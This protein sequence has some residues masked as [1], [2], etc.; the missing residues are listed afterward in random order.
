MAD[1]M[2]F[3]FPQQAQA[4]GS[5]IA[6]GWNQFLSDPRGRA[7]LLSFGSQ[8][9]QPMGFGQTPA[10]HLGM[11]FGAASEGAAQQQKQELA[12]EE[13]A[14]KQDLRGAQAESAVSRAAAAEARANAAT[15]GTANQEMRLRIATLQ[16]EGRQDRARSANQLRVTNAYAGYVKMQ[17]EANRRAALVGGTP[18]PVE[19]MDQWLQRH[20]HLIPLMQGGGAGSTSLPMGGVGSS[21]EVGYSVPPAGGTPQAG[22]A[23]NYPVAPTRHEDRVDGTIYVPREGSPN[24]SRW[25][26]RTR[27]W[28]PI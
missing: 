28:D 16:E 23:P 14:S 5:N 12:E 10:G 3:D 6:A 21:P 7:A 9:M 1:E 27:K 13:A 15:A 4:A 19:G 25:N 18:Q 17:N 2:P 8:L 22:G 20:P 26:A 24:A 11:G